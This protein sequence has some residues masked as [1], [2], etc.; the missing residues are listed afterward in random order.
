[1]LLLWTPLSQEIKSWLISCKSSVF[2]S[3]DSY[4]AIL[5][6]WDNPASE[7]YIKM[8]QKYA[9][10]IWIWCKIIRPNSIIASEAKQSIE[11]LNTDPDCIW[12]IV[13]LPLPFH[14][15]DFKNELLNSIIPSKDVD[16]L[17]KDAKVLPATV[18]G[19]LELRNY[20]QLW[21]LKDKNIVIIW[22]SQI[23]WKPLTTEC[24]KRWANV[25]VFDI[26]N[27]PFEI[28]KATKNAEII[29]SCTWNLNFINQDFIKKDKS[30]II[31]D[32]WYWYINGKPTG[33]IQFDQVEPFVKA[34][35]PVPG[36]VWPL[37][38]ASIFSNL[39]DLYQW[40]I[41]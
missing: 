13:Q 37:T 10:D 27:S 2:P 29:F 20:Y 25:Q 32:A 19:I 18:R 24:K 38:V 26:L 11:A 28:A 30:Q 40:K 5:L 21:D 14:L 6:F 36:G 33:D 4:L 16:W 9:S 12:I 22:Q 39:F 34:I 41:T 1:M 31:I 23:I 15:A 3:P 35:T 8:K 17:S 7:I